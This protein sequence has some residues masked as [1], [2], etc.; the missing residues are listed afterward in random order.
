MLAIGTLG[1]VSYDR[2]S[3]LLSA[4][5]TE[6]R[7]VRVLSVDRQSGCANVQF[8]DG[9][10]GYEDVEGIL[11]VKLERK[12]DNVVGGHSIDVRLYRV[13]VGVDD[14]FESSTS[15]ICVRLDRK[16]TRFFNGLMH[17]RKAQEVFNKELRLFGANALGGPHMVF[18]FLEKVNPF[19]ECGSEGLPEMDATCARCG[20]Q[21][22]EDDARWDAP[23][24]SIRAIAERLR[25]K[26]N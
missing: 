1:L 11:P 24:G 15:G 19:C 7:F 16:A 21:V 12:F 18:P 17:Y 3:D 9:S 10:K 2:W 5:Y 8:G 4:T 26:G 25:Q 22:R 23:K 14:S 20:G 6:H 13:L